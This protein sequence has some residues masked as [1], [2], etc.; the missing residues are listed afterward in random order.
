MRRRKKT[1][2]AYISKDTILEYINILKIEGPTYLKMLDELSKLTKKHHTHVLVE[3]V[4]SKEWKTDAEMLDD[5]EKFT[6]NLIGKADEIAQVVKEKLPDNINIYSHNLNISVTMFVFYLIRFIADL[7]DFLDS[8]A[9]ILDRHIKGDTNLRL[10]YNRGFIIRYI[11]DFLYLEKSGIIKDKG[12]DAI[13]E[14]IGNFPTGDNLNKNIP[15]KIKTEIISGVVGDTKIGKFLTK[16]L[17]SFKTG[18]DKYKTKHDHTLTRN[19]NVIYG[20]AGNPIYHIRKI[21][22]DLEINNYEKRKLE[23]KRLEL[24]LQYLK[25]KSSREMDPKKVEIYK[26]QIEILDEKIERLDAKIRAFEDKLARR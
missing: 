9:G 2:F 1:V 19:K 4:D 15:E 25:E 13:I 12:L 16:F 8:V 26:K 6:K 10:I 23:K 3:L 14:S 18:T 24:K 22:A 7:P 21:I 17:I 20:F 5:L 11:H